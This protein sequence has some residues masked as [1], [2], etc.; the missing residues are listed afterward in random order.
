MYEEYNDSYRSFAQVYDAFMD[1][2]PYEEWSTYL[3]DLFREYGIEDVSLSVL[4]MI[5][6]DGISSKIILP[7][8]DEE[9]KKLQKSAKAL[10]DVIN[11]LNI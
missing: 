5:G 11:L 9:V 7:L 1:N 8:E 6:R 10:K 4:N 3:A 2:V